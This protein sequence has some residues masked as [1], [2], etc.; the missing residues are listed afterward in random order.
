MPSVRF[1]RDKRGYEYVYLVH[2]V[3]KRG[4]PARSRV[5]YWYR[6]PPGVKIGREP[7]DPDVRAA[8]ER[9]HPG[10]DFDWDRIVSTPMPPPDMT[11]FWRERRR[12]ERAAKAER[13]AAEAALLASGGDGADGV[14]EGKAALDVE[15]AAPPEVRHAAEVEVERLA[16]PDHTPDVQVSEAS[17]LLSLEP[18][19]VPKSVDASEGGEAA[20]ASTT[21]AADGDVAPRRRRRR[22]GGRRRKGRSGVGAGESEAALDAGD[23]EPGAPEAGGEAPDGD[24]SPD[25]FEEE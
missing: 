21:S 5:L 20:R 11:E 19:G 9:Q 18:N 24:A 25:G 4:K 17:T 16:T 3:S 14:A 2:S 7:F 13:K 22:R 23:A 1:S 12:A 8:L 15:F 10:V 6:T